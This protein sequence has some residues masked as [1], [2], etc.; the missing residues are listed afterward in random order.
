MSTVR[1]VGLDP[2]LNNFGYALGIFDTDTHILNI[3]DIGVLRTKPTE[4]FKKKN[5]SDLVQAESIACRLQLLLHGS[6]FIFAEVPVGSQSSRAQASYGICIGLLA[7]LKVMSK[8]ILIN[9][10]PYDVKRILGNREVTK[11]EMIEWSYSLYP[12]LPWPKRNNKIVSSKAEHMADAIGALHAGINDYFGFY[13]KE[14][15][16]YVNPTETK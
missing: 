5:Q 1:V 10:S 11:Y 15:T 9:V 13:P 3:E 8:S 2:S 4:T 7:S 12:Q 14:R 6:D 16:D